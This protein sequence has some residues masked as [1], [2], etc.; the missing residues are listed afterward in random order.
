MEQLVTEY[1][2]KPLGR[3][4]STIQRGG[5]AALRQLG[6][7]DQKEYEQVLFETENRRPLLAEAEQQTTLPGKVMAGGT[8]IVLDFVNAF[9]DPDL[10]GLVGL[11]GVAPAAQKAVLGKFAL[12]MLKSSPEQLQMGIEAAQQGDLQGAVR[13]VGGSAVATALSAKLAG[14][15]IKQPGGI[16]PMS[17]EMALPW[18]ETL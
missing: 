15:V 10:L 8:Q 11:G 7:I 12:D 14:E 4:V 13:H 6:I 18:N 17:P 5:A 16:K 2:I 1:A 3:P 9:S